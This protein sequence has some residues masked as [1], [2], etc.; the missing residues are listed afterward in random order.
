MSEFSYEKYFFSM[1]SANKMGMEN[2]KSKVNLIKFVEFIRDILYSYKV[3][4][5]NKSII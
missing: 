1:V 4:L 2:I 3:T 5:V